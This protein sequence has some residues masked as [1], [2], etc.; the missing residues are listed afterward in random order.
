MKKSMPLIKAVVFDLDGTL[1]DTLDDLA[2]CYNRVLTALGFPT[3]PVGAYKLFIG[4]GARKCIERALPAGARDDSTIDH[5]LTLQKQ[6]YA[7]NWAVK[8]SPY[9]GI[10]ELLGELKNL[11]LPMAVLSN[12]DQVFAE[13][14]VDHHFGNQT[15]DVVMGHQ[16]GVPNKPDPSGCMNIANQMSVPANQFILLG[17]SGMDMQA[18]RR[19]GMLGLGALWGFRS[20]RELVDAGAFA[21]VETPVELLNF[22]NNKVAVPHGT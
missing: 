12:K 22:I 9:D 11:Q 18:A 1:L 7:E 10:K 2:D 13:L 15:F 4:D 17:D 16:M 6:D 20:R 21:L 3:H 14:C 19:S 8:T 5:C